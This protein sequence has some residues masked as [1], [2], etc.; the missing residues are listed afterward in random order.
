M[1][2]RA[3]MSDRLFNDAA[4]RQKNKAQLYEKFKKDELNAR[5]PGTGGQDLI[6]AKNSEKSNGKNPGGHG[7]ATKNSLPRER[8]LPWEP[9]AQPGNALRIVRKSDAN[10]A[11][12]KDAR[13]MMADQ[14]KCGTSASSNSLTRKANATNQAS[15]VFLS[16]KSGI[17]EKGCF[18]VGNDKSMSFPGLDKDTIQVEQ[19]T[20]NPGQR[21]Y[22]DAKTQMNNRKSAMERQ[23]KVTGKESWMAKSK[24]DRYGKTGICTSQTGNHLD[25]SVE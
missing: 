5:L 3:D 18:D 15:P 10:E 25:K 4:T 23:G 17:V 24:D 16:P 8:A 13:T 14:R 12:Q 21:L 22:Q 19:K 1:G 9:Q 6:K 20:T 7:P 11:F 2:Q